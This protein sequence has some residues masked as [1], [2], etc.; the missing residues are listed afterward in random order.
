G[1]RCR[2]RSADARLPDATMRPARAGAEWEHYRRTSTRCPPGREAP[3]TF[4]PPRARTPRATPWLLDLRDRND[5]ARRSG[6][7]LGRAFVSLNVG[8]NARVDLLLELARRI[9]PAI[10]E[11]L[12]ARHDLDQGRDVPP[13]PQR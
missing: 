11:D 7:R 12:V 2:P 1:H 6:Q 9:V 8:P 10:L 3:W 5:L 13:R 4:R